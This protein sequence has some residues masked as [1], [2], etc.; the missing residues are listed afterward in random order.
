MFGENR[1]QEAAGKWP[2]FKEEFSDVSVH[3][4]GP[5]QTNKARQAMELFDAIHTVDRREAC[6]DHSAF[7]AGI[8]PLSR[9]FCASEHRR[10]GAERQA[11][12]RRKLMVLSKNAA[13]LICLF[14]V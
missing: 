9:A 12:L 2:A 7:G 13:H 6:Q 14:K 11:F 1:V 4:I 5:L 8:G 3:L 10:R